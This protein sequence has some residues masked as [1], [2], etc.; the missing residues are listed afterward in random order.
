MELS[1]HCLLVHYLFMELLLLFLNGGATSVR[2][3]FYHDNFCC[4]MQKFLSSQTYE[5]I[6]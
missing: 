3:N 1:E 2:L 5:N 4:N 6:S